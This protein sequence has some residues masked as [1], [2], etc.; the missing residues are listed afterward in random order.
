MFSFSLCQ[1]EILDQV[2][3]SFSAAPSAMTYNSSGHFLINTCF[4]FNI[5]L[6][7]EISSNAAHKCHY[8][9]PLISEGPWVFAAWYWMND[10][11]QGSLEPLYQ[12]N[13]LVISFMYQFIY[14]NSLYILKSIM[15]MTFMPLP[16]N[17]KFYII[18]RKLPAIF[19]YQKKPVW[20][21]ST[22]T[23]THSFLTYICASDVVAWPYFFQV[24]ELKMPRNWIKHQDLIFRIFH[25][26]YTEYQ[27]WSHTVWYKTAFSAHFKNIQM[28]N[29]S[30]HKH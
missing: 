26:I 8:I 30:F 19:L 5:R 1:L 12:M 22:I 9:S 23:P 29:S 13:N 17:H 27:V 6:L 25:L 24:L 16:L 28:W 14:L 21:N 11:T 4:F 3:P 7:L 20:T 2:F 15:N 18:C 10:P